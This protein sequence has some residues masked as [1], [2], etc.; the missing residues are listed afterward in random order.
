MVAAS[1]TRRSGSAATPRTRG[2][3]WTG[4]AKRRR[5]WP[6]PVTANRDARRRTYATLPTDRVG[7]DR[8]V[9]PRLGAAPRIPAGRRDASGRANA[10]RD[11]HRSGRDA[12]LLDGV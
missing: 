6:K 12:L 5:H 4:S 2:T 1:T 7:A 10:G 9:A 11:R 8:S 3:R